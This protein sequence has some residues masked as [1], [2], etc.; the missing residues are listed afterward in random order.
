MKYAFKER[1]KE[2]LVYIKIINLE[3]HDFILKIG[4]NGVGIPKGFNYKTSHSLGISLVHKLVKQ[5]SGN[6]EQDYSKKGTHY[7]IN[8]KE[9]ETQSIE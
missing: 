5:L 6:L 3:S 4:A 9:I 8:F 7:I 1:S 2:D